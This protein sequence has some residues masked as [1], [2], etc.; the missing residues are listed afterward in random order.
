MILIL[1]ILLCNTNPLVN[2]ASLKLENGH[3]FSIKKTGADNDEIYIKKVEL[4]GKLMDRNYLHI[5]EI[6]KGGDLVVYT[7]SDSSNNWSI[8]DY[9]STKISSNIITPNPV[10]KAASKTFMG[11]LSISI[12]CYQCDSILYGLGENN[13]STFYKN[14]IIITNSTSISAIAYFNGVKSKI[15]K[16]TYIKHDPT[17][18][19]L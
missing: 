12:D 14:P 19:S 16:A 15:E 8:S 7:T 3:S 9:Y 17:I 5:D 4:N 10:I 13:M 1:E 18:K 11:T 6:M 2:S